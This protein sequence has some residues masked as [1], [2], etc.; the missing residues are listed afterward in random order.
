MYLIVIIPKYKDTISEVLIPFFYTHRRY[1]SDK[2]MEYVSSLT[3][4][5]VFVEQLM[6]IGQHGR[7]GLT[8]LKDVEELRSANECV[9]HHRT[10]V[11]RA[12]SCLETQL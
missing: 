11:E 8:A 7:R 6:D 9:F 4:G 3:C 2:Q 5:C 1:C 12:L 10:E